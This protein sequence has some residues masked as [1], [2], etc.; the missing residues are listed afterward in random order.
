MRLLPATI[1]TY[2]LLGDYC[3]GSGMCRESKECAMKIITQNLILTAAIILTGFSPVRMGFG[4]AVLIEAEAFDDYGGWTLDP[5]FA[6]QMGS[7][8]LLAHGLGRSVANAR[9]AVELPAASEY[10]VWVRTKDWVPSHHPG[11]FEVLIN[12]ESLGVEFGA[13]GKG[14]A[15]QSGGASRIGPGVVTVELK[16]ITGFDGRCDAI[17]LTT[18][19]SFVPPDGSDRGAR[20][21]RRRLLGLPETPPAAGE[22]D[23]VVVGGGVSGCSAALS[24]ARMGCRV[25]LVQNRPVL[26]GNASVEIGITPRGT[27]SPLVSE[28]V[29]RR[30][31][32][33]IRAEQVL[34]AEDN[35][36]L[37]LNFHAY[38]VTK[39]GDRITAVRARHTATNRELSF[40]AAVFIDA[41]GTAAIG[42]LA[43]ADCRA[44]REARSEFNESLAPK[45]P[46]Q[47]HHGNT[48]IFRTHMADKPSAFPDVPWA[49]AVSGDYADL[50][51]QIWRPG[52]DNRP[53]PFV[54]KLRSDALTHYWEYGQWLD[55][56]SEAEHI[57]DHLLCSL[58]GTFAT[59]KRKAP[60]IYAN[61]ELAYVGHV[62]ASG[63]FQRIV[64]DYILTEN[65]IRRHRSFPD[66][67]AINSG[68][69]CLHYPGKEHDFRLGHWQWVPVGSFEVPFRCLHS[70]NVGNLMMAGK[71]ISVTHVA[72]AATKTM[73]NGGQHG[74]A[75]GAA[76]FLCKKYGVMPRDVYKRHISELRE[77]V[78][79]PVNLQGT[80]ADKPD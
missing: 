80:S 34:R 12:G 18:D 43:G 15:W 48:V 24:A 67:V 79:N 11:R 26:G 38:A 44:G 52:V 4:A 31:G 59:V 19:L 77:I 27:R 64:G 7:P 1:V 70:H 16:D 21:W 74:V 62:L 78:T 14:W 13:N 28:L 71:H 66:T 8:Y 23:V 42:L 37:F 40:P 76:A 51:G 17:L 49:T 35:V 32:G 46:D 60:K 33:A 36:S 55:P 45:K 65:D 29:Q 73:L 20:S 9:T 3:V 5:Q 22:F 53:G 63:Q 50:G 72:G 47:M 75:V 69:F 56:Y 39:I 41:T 68:L 30:L 54:G 61:L 2:W 57:R 58:Y 10:K 6:D 25:A